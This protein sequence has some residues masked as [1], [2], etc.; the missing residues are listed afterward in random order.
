MN[1]VTA[2]HYLDLGLDKIQLGY[3][4]LISIAMGTFGALLFILVSRTC[5][6][7][8]INRKFYA[9]GDHRQYVRSL[10]CRHVAARKHHV[11]RSGRHRRQSLGIER[12]VRR[13]ADEVASLRSASVEGLRRGR[14]KVE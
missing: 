3:A 10:R 7:T 6:M 13:H 14:A 5:L 12:S 4:F 1:V 11:G 9:H 8:W 2:A